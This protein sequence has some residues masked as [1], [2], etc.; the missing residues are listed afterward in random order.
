MWP[1]D[2]LLRLVGPDSARVDMIQSYPRPG[3]DGVAERSRGGFRSRVDTDCCRGW[4]MLATTDRAVAV[5][6]EGAD[7]WL[8]EARGPSA[9]ADVGRWPRAL[10]STFVPEPL[11]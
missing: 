7:L 1:D 6:A 3:G 4:R 10:H 2:L 11:R 8:L 5:L 9:T